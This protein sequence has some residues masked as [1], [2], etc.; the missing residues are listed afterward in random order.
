MLR[1]HFPSDGSYNP[2]LIHYEP[3]LIIQRKYSM[4]YYYF[5]TKK[6]HIIIY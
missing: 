5:E 4:F 6:I 2:P 1:K 3:E